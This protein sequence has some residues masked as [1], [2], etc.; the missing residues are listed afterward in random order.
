MSAK[1][2]SGGLQ[3]VL[4]FQTSI[5]SETHPD[6]LLCEAEKPQSKHRLVSQSRRQPVTILAW[7]N[8]S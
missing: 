1:Y 2:H 4:Y 6:S 7:C 8:P 3:R 5:P